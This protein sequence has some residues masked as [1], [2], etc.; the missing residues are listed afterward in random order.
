MKSPFD[1]AKKYL[2]TTPVQHRAEP[3]PS[4]QT[5]DLTEGQIKAV[6]GQRTEWHDLTVDDSTT[7]ILICSSVLDADI[8]LALREDF[9]PDPDL[10]SFA[11]F[12]AREI[13]LL[14]EKTQ[15]TLRE[16]HQARLVFQRR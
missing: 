6:R 15:E 3:S 16:I 12:Y 1:V 10:P 7:G 13:P 8:W 2:E 11:V 4:V 9:K 5:S 14:R